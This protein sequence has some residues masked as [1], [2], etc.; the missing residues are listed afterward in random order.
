[1][2]VPVTDLLVEE[3]EGGYAE[4]L[5][6]GLENIEPLELR[7]LS[8]SNVIKIPVKTVHNN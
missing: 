8:E 2:N 6:E 4:D 1:M 7:R 5:S 3:N